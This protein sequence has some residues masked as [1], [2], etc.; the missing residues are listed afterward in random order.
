MPTLGLLPVLTYQCLSHQHPHKLT[1]LLCQKQFKQLFHSALQW[2]KYLCWTSRPGTLQRGAK[3]VFNLEK[4]QKIYIKSSQLN[5]HKVKKGA[6]IEIAQCNSINQLLLL[7]WSS[8]SSRTPWLTFWSLNLRPQYIQTGN[9]HDI[10]SF[11]TS[12]HKATTHACD[13]WSQ[14][15]IYARK[16]QL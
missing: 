3:L 5:T 11:L 4:S 6:S 16:R 9:C 10:L 8:F 15:G 1:E 14:Q 12:F 2:Q 13:L 7:Q